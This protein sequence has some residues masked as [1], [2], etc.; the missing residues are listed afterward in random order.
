MKRAI[1]FILCLFMLMS[2]VTICPD[3]SEKAIIKT[4]AS[5]Y[6]DKSGDLS[7]PSPTKEQIKTM[8]EQITTYETKFDIEPSVVSPYS[9]G[10]LN[11]DYLQNAEDYLNLIRYIAGL[12]AIEMSDEL[13]ES[14]QY[15]AVLLEASN[16]S[17]YPSQPADMDDDFYNK[18]F[19]ATSSSN[20]AYGYNDISGSISGYMGDEDSINIDVVGHRRWLLNPKLH[21]VGFGHAKG[22]YA[23]KVFDQS[24]NDVDYN[25]ISWPASGNFPANMFKYNDP[26]SITLNPSKYSKIGDLKITLTRTSDGKVWNFDSNTSKDPNTKGD[27]LNIDLSGAGVSNCIIFRPALNDSWGYDGIYT[28][29]VSGI[30]DKSGN[31]VTLKYQTDFYDFWGDYKVISYPAEIGG[32][33]TIGCD[34]CDYTET[35]KTDAYMSLWWNTNGGTGGFSSS[36]SNS[37]EV[38]DTLYLLDNDGIDI[39]TKKVIYV[40]DETAI[41]YKYTQGGD[42]NT[43]TFNKEGI[44]TFTICY[45]YAPHIYKTYM[46]YV[47]NTEGMEAPEPIIPHGNTT[48]VVTSPTCT[49]GGYTAEVCSVCEYAHKYTKTNPTGHSTIDDKSI[50][51][52]C[53]EVGYTKG[54]HCKTCGEVIVAQNEIPAKGHTEITS[55]YIKPTCT[56]IGYTEGKKCSDC[57]EIFEG[58]TEIAATGHT[59]VTTFGVEPTCTKKGYTEGSHCEACGEVIVAQKIIPAKGHDVHVIAYPE[60]EGGNCILGCDCGY[61]TE[62]QTYSRISV[63]WNRDGGY[64][65]FN[66]E[67]FDI[68]D[69][70][71]NVGDTLY[72][73]NLCEYGTG[74]E[75]VIEVSDPDAVKWQ[76]KGK[77]K[78]VF[79]FLYEGTYTITISY[80]YSPAVFKTYTVVVKDPNKVYNIGDIN[81]DGVIDKKDYAL[82]KR[83]CIGLTSLSPSQLMVA[84]MNGNREVN[85]QDYA[86]LKRYCLGTYTIE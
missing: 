4:L 57:G 48:T 3:I 36:F 18:G 11:A 19:A 55:P 80:K 70:P 59:E 77:S 81:E 66:E 40:S 30:Y 24:G 41:S 8:W 54:S 29:E 39:S 58:C 25:F 75:L 27:F 51:P 65:Y 52:T 42:R 73:S 50:E 2:V 22:S 49:E 9:I 84:D 82:L 37:F 33:C 38:G 78:F 20:I 46:V 44:Y 34:E 68:F 31:A 67:Y 74:S 83:Y 79:E 53:T 71:Y 64:D 10:A 32:E 17:H 85:K 43:F 69:T 72:G 16:F 62:I 13:N 86:F 63:L 12:P 28:V 76:Y 56:E 14:A 47:G 5:E 21:Y 60:T 7:V 26:W 15:G 1:S 45:R 6:T 61:V 35:F 23:T